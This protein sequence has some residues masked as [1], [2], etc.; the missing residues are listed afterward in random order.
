MPDAL[1]DAAMRL[2]RQY[3]IVGGMPECVLQ[4]RETRDYIF[5]RHLQDNILQSYLND[6]GKYNTTNE[7][8]K[9][10]L[11]YDNIT[12]QLSKKKYALSI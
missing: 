12:V 7:I 6:M 11:T 1:H 10:R 9:T 8:K 2:Y 4:F 5:V 3:L